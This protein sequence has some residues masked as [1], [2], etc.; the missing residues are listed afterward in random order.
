VTA[1][2]H[3]KDGEPGYELVFPHAGVRRW[4]SAKNFEKKYTEAPDNTSVTEDMV[5]N[6]IKDTEVFTIGEKTTVVKVT[7]INGFEIV[8]TSSCV[9]PA[10]YSEETG[11]EI[12]LDKIK[13]KIWDYLGFLLQTALYGFRQ[14]D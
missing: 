4:M 9:D 8:E 2:P 5:N 3:E 13:N 6:F 7:L 1:E 14:E 12:C 11:K 10:N